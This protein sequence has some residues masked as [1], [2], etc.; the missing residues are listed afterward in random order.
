MNKRAVGSIQR[1]SHR[2]HDHDHGVGSEGP[3]RGLCARLAPIDADFS[4]LGLEFPICRHLLE[5]SSSHVARVYNGHGRHTVGK[6]VPALLAV[7][8][9]LRHRL[10]GRK[11]F[12]HGAHGSLR[13][14][15]ADGRD[16][17]SGAPADDHP[18]AGAEFH[19]KKSGRP[20]LEGQAIAVALCGSDYCCAAL[21]VDRSGDPGCG[22]VDMADPRSAH[23]ARAATQSFFLIDQNPQP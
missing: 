21:P 11:P 22:S 19:I 16:C 7:V 14:R 17:V 10:D 1:R 4:E 23:Q 15:V 18:R 8:I 5:Q 12:H 3:T 2:D 6:L 20:R 9:P 13:R